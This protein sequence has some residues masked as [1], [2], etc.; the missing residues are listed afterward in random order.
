MTTKLSISNSPKH[1]FRRPRLRT[2]AHVVV[3][4]RQKL[5]LFNLSGAEADKNR[6]DL[7]GLD[8]PGAD[9]PERS[10]RITAAKPGRR[11]PIRQTRRSPPI[12]RETSGKGP[13]ER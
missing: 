8:P 4:H 1:W 10:A 6:K 13:A 2:G 12:Q 7:R 3:A 5:K 11:L 9:G